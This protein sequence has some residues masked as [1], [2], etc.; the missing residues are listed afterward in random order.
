MYMYGLTWLSGDPRYTSTAIGGED[1]DIMDQLPLYTV[2]RKLDQHL[3]F[4][5]QNKVHKPVF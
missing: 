3:V 1:M 5:K 2:V 4:K